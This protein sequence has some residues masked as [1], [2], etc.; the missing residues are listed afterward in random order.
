MTDQIESFAPAVGDWVAIFPN[1]DALF[2]MEPWIA[3][4]IIGWAV[5][6]TDGSDHSY[7]TE[8]LPVLGGAF[9]AVSDDW[10]G[11]YRRA[12]LQLPDVRQ[13]LR[14]KCQRMEAEV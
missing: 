9:V 11:V 8:I 1:P 10:I 14:E 3:E 13:A 7:A 5:L 12:D 2:G 4:P 6:A